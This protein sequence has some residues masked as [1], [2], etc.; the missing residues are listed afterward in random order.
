MLDHYPNRQFL[1]QWLLKEKVVNR[2][3]QD[4]V[5]ESQNFVAVHPNREDENGDDGDDGG[6]DV[7]VASEFEENVELIDILHVVWMKVKSLFHCLKRRF[8]YHTGLL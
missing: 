5:V 8:S 6:D 4:R 3:R 2:H 1:F 7:V